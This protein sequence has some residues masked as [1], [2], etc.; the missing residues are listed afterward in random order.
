MTSKSDVLLTAG[1]LLNWRAED[2]QLDEEIRQLQQ[3]RSE[4]KRKLDAAEVIAAALSLSPPEP[5]SAR[6]NGQDSEDQS[7]SPAVALCANLTKTG[8]SL[9]A[10]QVRERLIDLGFAERLKKTPSYHYALLHRLSH[11][12]KLIKRGSKY[13]A[14]PTPSP[15]GETEAVGASVRH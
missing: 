12:G 13:R 6:A 9:K 3:R 5:P 10:P 8:E 15:E 2:K 11:N 1:D 14:A 4:I 7:D